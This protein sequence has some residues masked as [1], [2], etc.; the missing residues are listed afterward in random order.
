MKDLESYIFYLKKE[1]NY[2]KL[3]LINY[4]K[5]ITLFL[6]YLKNKKKSYIS[7]NKDDVRDYLK[8]MDNLKYKNSTIS[9]SLSSL[10]N[11][12]T[13]LLSKNIID[14]NPFK[15]IRN[16]KK[17]K[18]LPNFLQYNEFIKL[19]E[20]LKNDDNLSIRNKMILELLYATGIRVSELTNI[21]LDDINFNDKSIRVLG[22]GNKERIVYFGDYAKDVMN[23]YINNNRGSLLNGK[24]SKYLLINKNGDNL[25]SRGVEEVIDKIVKEVSLNHKISP[26]VLRH[27]FATHMLEDGADLRTVQELLGHSSLSTTQIYTHVTNERLRSVYLKSFPRKKE[28]SDK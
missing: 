6:D 17:E 2:A 28:K 18:K 22:K 14:N 19:I 16:P 5:D 26:H 24:N 20:D 25:T 13:Y 12:Y 27:T 21:K 15:L 8:Y 7:I 1:R 9:R 23:E 10:R 4:S 3:T 11:F